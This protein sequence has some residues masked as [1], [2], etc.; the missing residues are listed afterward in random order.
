MAFCGLYPIGPRP[1]FTGNLRAV[2][3]REGTQPRIWKAPKALCQNSTV[4]EHALKFVPGNEANLLNNRILCWLVGF[5]SIPHVVHGKDTASCGCGKPAYEGC[6]VVRSDRKSRIGVYTQSDL[7]PLRVSAAIACW[8]Q[9]IPRSS[10]T[11]LEKA[12]SKE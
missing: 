10:I 11:E 9:S 2:I 1:G 4:R 7:A 12:T 8:S 5:V 3:I 6:D